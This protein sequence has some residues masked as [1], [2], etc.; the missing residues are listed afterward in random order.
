M[1]NACALIK[2]VPTRAEQI[3]GAV[4][5]MPSVK[6]AYFCYGRFDIAVFI[7]AE[8]YKAV[9]EISKKINTIEGVRSTETLVEA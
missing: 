1:L 4:L 7:E 5:G 6:K 8:D 2:I 9:R 3:L